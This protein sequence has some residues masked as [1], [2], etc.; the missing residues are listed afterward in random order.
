MMQ[1]QTRYE[2]LQ[3]DSGARL[4][5]AEHTDWMSPEMLARQPVQEVPIAPIDSVPDQTVKPSSLMTIQDVIDCLSTDC[6]YCSGQWTAMAY[7][8]IPGTI[9]TAP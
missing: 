2:A 6:H 5:C 1:K 3:T 4:S 9:P 7:K 8:M